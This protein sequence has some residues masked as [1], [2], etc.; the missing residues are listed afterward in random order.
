[1]PAAR[2]HRVGERLPAVIHLDPD[3]AAINLCR[4]LVAQT[5]LEAVVLFGSQAVGGWDEQ[6]D[7]DLIIITV[8]HLGGGKAITD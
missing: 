8:R 5:D 1:M 3:P 2:R 6:S 7:L 4:K